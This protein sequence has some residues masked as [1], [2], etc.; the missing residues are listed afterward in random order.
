MR[1]STS[2]ELP[3][4]TD[5]NPPRWR[6]FMKPA[7]KLGFLFFLLKGIAWLVAGW[8]AWSRLT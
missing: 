2:V 7:I 1:L 3:T 4:A 5:V 6:R 8:F